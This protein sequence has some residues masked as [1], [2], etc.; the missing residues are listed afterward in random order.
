[1]EK[2]KKTIKNEMGAEMQEALQERGVGQR[3]DKVRWTVSHERRTTERE[4][5]QK[6]KEKRGNRVRV[7]V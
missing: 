4:K 5:T 6:N 1:M 7:I 3:K 2:V